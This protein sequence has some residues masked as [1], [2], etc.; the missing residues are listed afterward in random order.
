MCNRI[1][2]AE[3]RLAKWLLMCRD[4]SNSDVMDI[5]QE[6]AALMLGSNRVSVTQAAI[7]LQERRYIVYSRG[8]IEIIDRD[9]LEKF[10]CE[11]YHRIREEYDRLMA[12]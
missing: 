1:H 5:T 6:F 2:V 9:G 11:C 10:S 7:Q 8:R 4:R 12:G 3:Q